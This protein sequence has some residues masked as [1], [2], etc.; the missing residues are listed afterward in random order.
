MNNFVKNKNSNQEP[1]NSARNFLIDR[2]TW[3]EARKV[4]KECLNLTNI[5]IVQLGIEK[6]REIEQV[7]I[8]EARIKGNY[9]AIAQYK[10]V[11]KGGDWPIIFKIRTNIG[12]SKNFK[13]I[14]ITQIDYAYDES[15]K[16]IYSFQPYIMKGDRLHFIIK[17]YKNIEAKILTTFYKREEA[18]RGLLNTITKEDYDGPTHN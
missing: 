15:F 12:K 4:K 8:N 18:W 5:K 11:K 2:D 1:K 7:V 13:E 14:Y 17:I 16:I 3:L 6:A 10:F 9:K